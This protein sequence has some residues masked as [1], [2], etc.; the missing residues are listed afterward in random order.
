[1]EYIFKRKANMARA[2]MMSDQ[3]EAHRAKARDARQRRQR[4]IAMRK[5]DF[6]E[7]ED[8]GGLNEQEEPTVPPLPPP[9]C[10]DIPSDSMTNVA[11]K[12]KKSKKWFMIRL[13]FKIKF[14]Q[15]NHL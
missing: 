3:A 5:K 2:K 9:K 1:M 7:G 14:S 8:C 15:K 13:R 10:C 11:N 6:T 4:R 12:K